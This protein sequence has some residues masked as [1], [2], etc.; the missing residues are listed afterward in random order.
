[1]FFLTT[2]SSVT[3]VTT[4]KKYFLSTLGKINLTNMTTDVMFSGQGFAI[5]AM[6][7]CILQDFLF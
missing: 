3:A 2:V 5:V 1:M 7:S 4:V 6:F